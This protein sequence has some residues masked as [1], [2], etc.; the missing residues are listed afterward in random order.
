LIELIVGC[1][2]S[3]DTHGENNRCIGKLM[4]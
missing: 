4:V 1:I 3:V 2:L